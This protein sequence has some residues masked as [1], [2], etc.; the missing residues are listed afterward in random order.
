LD[1]ATKQT[2]NRG[3]RVSIASKSNLFAFADRD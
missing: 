1:A 3:E 2:L